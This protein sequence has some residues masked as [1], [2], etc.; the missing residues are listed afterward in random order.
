MK[1]ILI[2]SGIAAFAFA[3]VAAAATTT[4]STNLTVGSKGAD[5]SALQTWLISNGFHISSIESGATTPGYFGS[6]TQSAVKLYQASK[7]IPNTGF[8]GPLTRAALNGSSVAM[9]PV[10]TSC[11]VGYTC[12]VTPVAGGTMS[13]VVSGPTGITTPGVPGIMSVTAGPLSS[14]VL[15]VGAQQVPVLAIR[16]QAQYSDLA[17][18]SLNL[19]LGNNTSVFNKIFNKIYVTNGSTV[20]ASQPLNSSTVIQ[21]GNNYI[22]GLAGFNF[23]VP[24]GT[25][26]DIIIK[27]DLN[28]SID[29]AYLA[30][31]SNYPDGSHAS[32]NNIGGTNVS[33]W[34][35]GL[36]AN[37]LRAVDGAG[38][39]LN[40]AG[41]LTA[42]VLT[43]NKSLVDN[44]Q[45]NLS[46][47][48]S[49]PTTNTVP[50]SDTINGNY[51]GLPIYTFDVYAQNDTLHLHNVAVN[52]GAITSGGSTGSVT[53]AYL[54]QGSTQVQSASVVNG[55]ASFSNITDGTNGATIPVGT[56]VPFT[57]KVDVTGVTTGTI[58]ITA[59]T[60][61]ANSTIYN[62]IDGNVAIVGSALGNTLTVA[63]KGPSFVLASAP[64]VTTSGSNQSGTTNSTSTIVA[65]FPLSITSVGVDT[66]FGDSASTTPAYWFNVIDS[67]GAT[68]YSGNGVVSTVNTA[69]L[70]N[71]K[72]ILPTLPTAVTNGVS[73]AH[74]YFV[75]NQNTVALG[76]VQFQFDGKSTAGVNLTGGPYKV[77]LKQVVY[78]NNGAFGTT[79]FMN[80]LAAWTTATGANP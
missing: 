6:Q 5:V 54:F 18:Q 27:A 26:K 55:V 67:T 68:V 70:N 9:T 41:N 52:I 56:T 13:P 14:T 44:A 34:A 2:A 47:D 39:N 3:A 37:Q 78:I 63:G 66:Y 57:V 46:V 51:L 77:N 21:S 32:I 11:P 65:S 31:G 72:V 38:I 23:V 71:V 49:S 28:S 61:V 35:I 73:A 58:A 30:G 74:T 4:F 53:A 12:T 69:N 25:Y 80:G 59:S 60:S 19:D 43:I 1:K 64:S 40:N 50:V 10:S 17:V 16:V 20:L 75:A 8:V 45:A 42:T 29:S 36:D 7:G 48:G 76:T 62:S 22:V 33:G 24:K 15:N 79:S